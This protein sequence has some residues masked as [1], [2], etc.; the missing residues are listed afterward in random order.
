MVIF[1]ATVSDP[2]IDADDLTVEW[3]SD[4]DGMLGTSDPTSLGQVTFAYGDLSVS[5][6]NISMVVTD[7]VGESCT[8]GVLYT[9]V[10]LLKSAFKVR[11][12]GQVMQKVTPSPFH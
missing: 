8:A 1:E 10:R 2:D 5:T 6:H 4:K 9:V 3:L 11:P 12:M 7:G